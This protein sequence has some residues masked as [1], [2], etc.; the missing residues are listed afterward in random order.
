MWVQLLVVYLHHQTK[1]LKKN[2]MKKSTQILLKIVATGKLVYG[3]YNVK[4]I[5]YET[6]E[7]F[8]NIGDVEVLTK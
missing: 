8:M 2:N 5:G 4:M 7:G 6:I 1:T 3:K